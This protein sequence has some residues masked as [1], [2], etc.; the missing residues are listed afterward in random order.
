MQQTPRQSNLPSQGSQ[1]PQNY[2]KIKPILRR[3]YQKNDFSSQAKELLKSHIRTGKEFKFYRDYLH[4]EGAKFSKK[5]EEI[6][7]TQKVPKAFE[8]FLNRQ[9]K[10][11]NAYFAAQLK[12]SLSSLSSLCLYIREETK[13][14]HRFHL[15]SKNLTS[16]T[17]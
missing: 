2:P 12:K 8:Y 17:P 16:L 15:F 4:G 6:L 14:T 9:W 11:Q 7:R 10:F 5:V 3:N 1:V 13:N